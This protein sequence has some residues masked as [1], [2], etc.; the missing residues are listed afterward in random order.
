MKQ[1]IEKMIK[2]YEDVINAGRELID[3]YEVQVST[4]ECVIERLKSLLDYECDLKDLLLNNNDEKIQ[5]LN[6][7]CVNNGKRK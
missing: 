1:E 6:K 2:D 7:E 3:Y 5:F 4:L